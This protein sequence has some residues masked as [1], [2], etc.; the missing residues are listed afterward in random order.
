MSDVAHEIADLLTN[1]RPGEAL[2]TAL[3]VQNLTPADFQ[4]A[5]I[6]ALQR[7]GIAV[8]E[9]CPNTGRQLAHFDADGVRQAIAAGRPELR[10]V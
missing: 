6:I 2:V 8:I 4:R 3:T 7:R 10:A 1:L 9:A 5:A